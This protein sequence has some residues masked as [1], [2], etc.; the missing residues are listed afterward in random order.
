M[1]IKWIESLKINIY[2]NQHGE[3]IQLNKFIQLR[4]SQTLLKQT[5]KQVY[6]LIQLFS[7]THVCLKKQRNSWYFVFI[8]GEGGA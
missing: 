6:H 2:R 4:I 5:T 7:C 8:T 1:E 3:N